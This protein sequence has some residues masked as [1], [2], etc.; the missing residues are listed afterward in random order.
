[1][2]KYDKPSPEL[3]NTIW[4]S[5]A[6]P[7][8]NEYP[9]TAYAEE[10]WLQIKPPYQYE[11]AINYKHD[12]FIA[13]INQLG[14]V[15]WDAE[16]QYQA[17]KS[18]VQASNNLTYKC[19]QTHI[20][21]NPATA[22]NSAYWERFGRDPLENTVAQNVLEILFPV[23]SVVMRPTNPGNSINSGGLGFGSWTKI[24]GR[25]IIGE[26]GYR[27]SRGEYRSFSRG[28]STGEYRHVLT[29]G[30]MPRHR[31]EGSTSSDTH[32]HN[33][34]SISGGG[35]SF[36]GDTD[37]FRSESTRSTSSDT[38]NHSFNTNYKGSDD[39]HNNIHPVFAAPI[40]YRTS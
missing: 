15:E 5:G 26:G 12:Q 11:N 38:H 2:P 7:T 16:T 21:K 23:G 32:N 33:Y 25:S 6:L 28:S 18:Y 17:G 39:P 37:A 1:M 20:N 31:H 8:N 30:E 24:Q 34:T 29:D 35:S 22:G 36:G 14:I 40:W 4:A 10:G 19:T 9:D 27:D 13:H 3:L